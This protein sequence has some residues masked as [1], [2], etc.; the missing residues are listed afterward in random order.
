MNKLILALTVVAL[1][2]CG[3]DTV[4]TPVDGECQP[5]SE[6]YS[7]SVT[8]CGEHIMENIRNVFRMCNP[9]VLHDDRTSGCVSDLM[10]KALEP[11]CD[12][13]NVC[14]RD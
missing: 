12:I 3:S 1:I 10:L 4:E 14:W 13:V 5:Y 7:H 6:N 9:R 8:Y 2:A 11:E